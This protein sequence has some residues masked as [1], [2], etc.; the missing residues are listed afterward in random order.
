MRL[1]CLIEPRWLELTRTSVELKSLSRGRI[2]ILQLTDFHASWSDDKRIAA[3]LTAWGQR[4]IYVSRGV[5][6]LFGVRFR[7]RPEVTVLDLQ[8]G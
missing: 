8:L 5:G 7:C 3:G 1:P 2:R 4:R 6:T